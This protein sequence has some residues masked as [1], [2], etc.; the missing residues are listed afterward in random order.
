M[1]TMTPWEEREKYV[2][3]SQSNAIHTQKVTAETAEFEGKLRDKQVEIAESAEAKKAEEE[4]KG[5]WGW[6]TTVGTTVGCMALAPAAAAQCLA[7]GTAAGG[8]ARLIT[9]LTS[10][11]EGSPEGID[12]S[13]AKYNKQAWANVEGDIQSQLDALIEFDENVWKQDVLLQ[14][15]DT[16]TA[17]KWGN[18]LD[19][20][21]I[22]ADDNVATMDLVPETKI[23]IDTDL[24]FD[25]NLGLSNSYNPPKI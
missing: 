9:D 23:D 22:F 13:G 24:D 10:H 25:E 20:L 21:G 18:T 11:A 17:Y 14:A 3:R 8:G 4:N 15:S 5:F 1:A 12:V 19:S 16:W 2:S 6:L 7:L